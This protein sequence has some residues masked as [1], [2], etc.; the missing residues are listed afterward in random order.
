MIF[1]YCL[2]GILGF[3]VIAALITA[4][5]CFYRI[6]YSPKRNPLGE[7]EYE[8]PDGEIYESRRD[9]IIAW[10]KAARASPC[11]EVEI[12]S[13]DGLTLRGKY[14]ECQAGATLEILFHGYQGNA[15][16]DL[17]G[18]IERCF[19]LGRNVL[20]VD[21][22]ASGR[23]DGHVISFGINERRDCLAWIDFAVSKFGSDVK[24]IITGV[25]MGGATVAMAASEELPPNVVCALADCPYTSPEEIIK[26]VIGEMKL[27]ANILY[28]FVRLGARIFGGFN[29]DE[30]SPIES[31]ARAKIPII[32]IH[33]DA[34]G[35]VPCEMSQR[36][37]ETCS[38]K[39]K[40][41]FIPGAGHGLAFP[42]NKGLYLSSLSDF[43]KE[44][45]F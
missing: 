9:E 12:K 5:I 20:L 22:R 13:F 37:F 43:Q 36:L 1:L 41:V 35:F 44:C 21:H 42:Q 31:V 26:K 29:I 30:A 27:P 15:E 33:G 6:F 11:E 17:S 28:P 24:I 40:L 4:F 25:S 39:K 23:S 16:R 32:F 19:S 2:L 7:D 8:V 18:G 10:V 14:Y 38:S 34:D 45:G 3:A